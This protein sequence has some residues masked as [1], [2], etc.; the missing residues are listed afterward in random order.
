MQ[1]KPIAI[2]K[3]CALSLCLLS[4]LVHAAPKPDAIAD[5]LRIVPGK[6]IGRVFIG[7]TPGAVR[8]RLGKPSRTFKLAAGASSELW[9]AGKYTL[10][11]V[12]KRGKVVQI[13]TTNP[14]FMVPEG[15]GSNDSIRSWADLMGENDEQASYQYPNKPWQHYYDWE[16]DGLAL[17]TTPDKTGRL[18]V[19]TVI[20]HPEDTP[21][22]TDQ[23]GTP[24][25]PH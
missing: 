12:Y 9:R 25:R 14:A 16:G 2:L 21:V 20:V 4:P 24:G 18:H 23:G 13:E 6:R 11:V 1:P 22:I 5:N 10:E 17:E 7:D 3:T 15:L 19:L 8:R